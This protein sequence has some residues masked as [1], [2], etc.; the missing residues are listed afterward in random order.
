MTS[1]IQ[2]LHENKDITIKVLRYTTETTDGL[3][4]DL[5]SPKERLEFDS[6]KSTKR[7]LE[8]Y[9]TRLLWQSFS[10]NEYISYFD[11]GKPKLSNAHISISHSQQ[12]VAIAFSPTKNVGLDIE[13]ESPIIEKIKGKYLH[14]NEDFSSL[15]ELTK[16]WTIKEA[17]YKLV[18]SKRLFFKEHIIVSSIDPN[19]EVKVCI[20]TAWSSP[21]VTCFALQNGFHLTYVQ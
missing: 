14:E 9:H 1:N 19:I 4:T 18:D 17:I 21:K 15:G 7:Q 11:S 3:K 13:Q 20:N 2:I 12:I 8:Y 10:Q 6:F 16:I 5:F